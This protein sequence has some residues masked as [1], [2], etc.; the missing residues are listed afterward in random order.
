MDVENDSFT[1]FVPPNLLLPIFP[2]PFF[3]FSF[4]FFSLVNFPLH[5]PSDIF[6]NPFDQT[7][8]SLYLF[9][10][11]VN[12]EFTTSCEGRISPLT[13]ALFIKYAHGEKNNLF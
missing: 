7:S 12:K 11:Q 8:L 2:R 5:E 9:Y 3:S 13:I 6:T 4:L 1:I 10:L